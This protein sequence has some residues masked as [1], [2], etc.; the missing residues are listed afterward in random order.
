MSD[1]SRPAP[2]YLLAGG[3]GRRLGR[4]PVLSR[5]IE[6]S[7]VERPSIAYIGA[8]SG[9]S[10]PFFEMLAAYLVRCGAGR[11]ELAATASGRAKIERTRAL[12]E[13]SDMILMSGGDVE[14]GMAVL[15]ERGLTEY[16]RGLHARG[17]PFFGISAGSIM[18]ARQ[19]IRWADE[20]DDS[21]A[22]L[23]PCLGIAPVNCDT[24]GEEEGWEELRVLLR[25]CPEGALGYGIPS[26]AAL[27]VYPDGAV[28]AVGAPV[29]RFAARDGEARDDGEVRPAS[30]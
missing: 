2:V 18:L 13:A 17:K 12:L 15:E 10:K 14:E 29:G 16:L 27:G 26:G 19:W 4:D 28:E 8:A 25:L 1:L 23:F 3:P 5:A 20:D 7:R 21:T 6:S 24:H 9:D 11:V 22:S 30:R